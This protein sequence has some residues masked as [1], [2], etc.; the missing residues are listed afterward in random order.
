[1][2]KQFLKDLALWAGKKLVDLAAEKAVES[3]K[4]KR[5]KAPTVN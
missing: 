2:W 5:G 1:M 3:K 4:P